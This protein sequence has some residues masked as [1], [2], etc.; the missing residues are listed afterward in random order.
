MTFQ[1]EG[2]PL[3]INLIVFYPL[4]IMVFFMVIDMIVG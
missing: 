1:V 2:L 3:A 4:T